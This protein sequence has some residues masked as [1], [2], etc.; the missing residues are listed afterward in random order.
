[1]LDIGPDVML[2]GGL[3]HFIPREAHDRGSVVYQTHDNRQN[4]LAG[5]IGKEDISQPMTVYR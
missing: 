2:S 1:M 4:L 3:R 5:A